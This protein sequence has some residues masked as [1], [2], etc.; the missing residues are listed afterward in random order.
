MFLTDLIGAI[1]E[2]QRSEGALAHAPFVIMLDEFPSYA[3][4]EFAT[5]FEQAR[6]AGVALVMGAQTV[7]GLSDRSAGLS[8][9]FRDRVL[10]NCAHLVSFRIG[11]G[12][13]AEYLS[14]YAG[15]HDRAFA[16]VSETVASGRF[17]SP[18]SFWAWLGL[19]SESRTRARFSGYRVARDA[20]LESRVLTHELASRGEAVWL[21][22][23]D[24]DRHPFRFRAVWAEA[25]EAPRHWNYRAACPQWSFEPPPMLELGAWVRMRQMAQ[26]DGRAAGEPPA[27]PAPQPPP[28][29][30]SR[31]PATA[32]GTP[33]RRGRTGQRHIT[34]LPPGR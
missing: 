26:G 23:K 19:S 29:A 13:G 9:G 28:G 34:F 8:D 3:V 2:I 12:E 22:T 31:A 32:A 16:Q 4:P 18:L 17:W 15:R 5:V 14:R 20:V 10:G 1:D 6:S 7:S 33:R 27:A 21:S 11:P 24:A 25:A 30:A